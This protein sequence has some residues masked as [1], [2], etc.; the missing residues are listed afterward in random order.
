L[1][2]DGWN[3]VRMPSRSQTLNLDLQ[4]VA[5][6]GD[7]PLG[8]VMTSTA[9]KMSEMIAHSK[10]PSAS[11]M[12]YRPGTIDLARQMSIKRYTCRSTPGWSR[13]ECV[14]FVVVIVVAQGG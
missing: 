10:S 7:C 6:A 2:S 8:R 3:E 13:L 5:L 11:A 9:M 1:V 4:M 14:Y 12:N